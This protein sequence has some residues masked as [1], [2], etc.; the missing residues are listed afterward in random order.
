MK[1]LVYVGKNANANVSN[2]NLERVSVSKQAPT[3]LRILAEKRAMAKRILQ[4]QDKGLSEDAA[5]VI[6][7]AIKTMLHS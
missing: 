3:K 6:A 4:K 7:E 1:P 5:K 2:A